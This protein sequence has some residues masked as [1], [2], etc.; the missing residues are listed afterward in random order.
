MAQGTE[1]VTEQRP[2]VRT[3]HVDIVSV[4]GEVYWREEGSEQ[5]RHCRHGAE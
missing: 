2:G 1:T 3:R 5:R 4:C